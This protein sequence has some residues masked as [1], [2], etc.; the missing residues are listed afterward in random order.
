MLFCNVTAAKVSTLAHCDDAQEPS[1]HG[2]LF[3]FL[4]HS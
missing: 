3:V 1:A 2:F 4:R